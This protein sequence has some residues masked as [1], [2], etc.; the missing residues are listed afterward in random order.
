[1]TA[2]TFDKLAYIDQL[3]A[4]G[5]SEPQARGMADALGQALC[6]KVATKND[7]VGLRDEI[8]PNQRDL[9]AAMRANKIDLLQWIAILIAAQTTVLMALKL[10]D[11]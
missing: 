3:K 2:M 9:L 5:F 1:M 7:V 4:A 6:E 8:V 10:L 11:R